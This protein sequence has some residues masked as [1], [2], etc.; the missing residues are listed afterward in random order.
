MKLIIKLLIFSLG[1]IFPTALHAKIEKNVC[2]THISDIFKH[3]PE[4]LPNDGS[5]IV[6]YD[7]DRTI[8]DIEGQPNPNQVYKQREVGN[9]E[10]PGTLATI[11]NLRDKGFKN[12][13]VTARMQGYG[14][15]GGH[16]QLSSREILRLANDYAQAMI[17]FLGP[18]WVLSGPIKENDMQSDDIIG[19]EAA[20]LNKKINRT[21]Q[22]MAINQIVYAPGEVKGELVSQF[23]DENKFS[24]KPT[25][26]IFIDNSYKNI[27]AFAN[28]FKDRAELVYLFRYPDTD[29]KPQ[30][31]GIKP[32]ADQA[33]LD[34]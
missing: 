24:T 5:L 14:R 29:P 20:K 26:I 13:V 1:W 10:R 28:V 25:H 3:L 21:L 15:S 11:K 8:S 19:K 22:Y 30:S 18:E 2:I 32:A 12:M 27:E 17:D 7:W 34:R 4:G 9:D 23:A 6:V 31:N 16:L 33:C